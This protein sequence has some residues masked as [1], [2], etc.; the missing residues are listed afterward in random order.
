MRLYVLIVLVVL[1]PGLYVACGQISEGNMKLNKLTP[2]EEKVIIHKGT[3]KPFSGK[4]E[5]FYE[6]GIYTCKQ[7][8]APLYRS[9]DK[10]DAECGWPSFDDE[11]IGAIKRI[12]DNDG[13]RTEIVCADCGG[14]LGHVFLGEGFTPKN[15]RHCVNS[16]SLNFL[17][18]EAMTKTDTAIFAGGCFWGVEYY[19]QKE[20]GVISTTVGYTG[21]AKQ[22]PTYEEVCAHLTGHYEAIEIVFD[23]EKTSYE[24]LARL[25]FEIHDPTQADGQGPDI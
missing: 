13:F 18:E 2:E 14:H 6:A 9:E 11:I 23:P 17:S 10:F 22:N 8:G 20:P 19:M 12:P 24:K 21:G 7:C 25:F 5:N 1:L 3:E 15:T 16:V 4:Y